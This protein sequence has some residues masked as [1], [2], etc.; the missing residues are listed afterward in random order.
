[1]DNTQF[2]ELSA[3]ITEAGLA[4]ESESAIL[5]GFCEREVARGLGLER[6]LVLIDT[7]HP[8]YEGRAFRWTRAQKEAT[9][10]EYGRSDEDLSRWQHSPFFRLEESGESL[11]RRRLTVETETEFSIFPELRA[12]GMTDYLAIA[13]RFSGNDTIGDMDCV[14]SSWATAAPQG[15]DDTDIAHLC[16]LMPFLALAVKSAS[17]ARIAG[18]L[19]ETYLGRDPGRRVLKG[20]IARGVAERIEAVLWFSDLRGYTRISDTASPEAIIP[21]L[22]HYADAIISAIHE[23]DGDV[24]KLIG[25]GVLAIFTAEDRGRAC[26]AALAA[27]LAARQ[28]V[29]ILNQCRVEKGLAITD[30][31]LA[32]HLGDVFYGN[33]GS[34][35]RLDFTVVGPAVNEVSRIAAMCRS[36]DQPLL[37]SSAFAAAVGEARSRLVSVGRYA[38]RGVGRPQDL[39]TLEGYE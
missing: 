7:L 15:F 31:Y 20:R 25:D 1:M 2:A 21:F 17:L 32:L 18:T 34:K 28:S 13:N 26:D 4:G 8:I 24:L 23:R 22:N 19:V 27:A 38:L 37:V 14:Y 36:V 10:T 39:F 5:A 30:M 6:A 16:Q 9:L 12:D 35:E 29:T 11:L 33:I 3:W